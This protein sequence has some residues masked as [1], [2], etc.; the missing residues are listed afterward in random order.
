MP[1]RVEKLGRRRSTEEDEDSSCD[2]GSGGFFLIGDFA[3]WRS[4]P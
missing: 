3:F 4:P 1:T 2:T